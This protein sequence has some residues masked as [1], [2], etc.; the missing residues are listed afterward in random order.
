MPAGKAG[1]D[2]ARR[3]AIQNVDEGRV[4]GP[5]AP[6]TV[7]APLGIN[8]LPQQSPV[9]HGLDP[10]MLHHTL[11]T[12]G[13]FAPTTSFQPDI[14]GHSSSAALP[15]ATGHAPAP[16]STPASGFSATRSTR[17]AAN[18]AVSEYLDPDIPEMGGDADGLPAADDHNLPSRSTKVDFGPS[19][20]EREA[21]R[22]FEDPSESKAMDLQCEGKKMDGMHLQGQLSFAI[23]VCSRQTRW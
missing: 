15:F 1:A 2:Q 12:A 17:G 3:A 22:L 8:S 10:A 16:G 7:V 18:M 4:T 13:S 9:R 5:L 6:N 23:S 14:T 21:R 11:P 20:Q 19:Q